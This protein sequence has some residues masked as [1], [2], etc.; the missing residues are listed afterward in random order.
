MNS[1][2]QLDIKIRNVVAFFAFESDLNLKD[3]RKAFKDECFFDTLDNEKYTFRVVAIRIGNPC[4]TFLIYRTGQVVCTGVKT[5][6]HAQQSH[7]YLVKRFQKAG[8]DVKLK[9]K[10]KITNIVATTDIGE[11][12][13]L[14]RFL[15]EIEKKRQFQAIYEPE[16][17]PAAIIKSKN[18]SR[19]ATILLFSNGKIVCVGLKSLEEAHSVVEQ[20]RR[21]IT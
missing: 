4:C 1:R 3:I 12:I 8:I 2:V 14:E 15:A 10:A 16:Q 11:P 6:R 20:I 5:V 17:F 13:D 21:E 18:P 7:A 9:Q 19:K